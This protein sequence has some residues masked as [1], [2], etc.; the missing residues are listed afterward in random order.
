MDKAT[1]ALAE[2]VALKDLKDAIEARTDFRAPGAYEAHQRDVAEYE[3]R[4]Q[5]AWEAARS[6]LKTKEQR[7]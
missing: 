5:P 6:A 7:S 4:K 3:R 1:E 2:L